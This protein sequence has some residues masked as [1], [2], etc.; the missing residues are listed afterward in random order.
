MSTLGN[1][2]KETVENYINDQKNTK[3]NAGRLKIKRK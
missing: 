1:M 2:G 3:S